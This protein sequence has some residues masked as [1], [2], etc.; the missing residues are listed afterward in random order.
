MNYSD[1]NERHSVATHQA[2]QIIQQMEEKSSFTKY[3]HGTLVGLMRFVCHGGVQ[4][5]ASHMMVHQLA[6]Q[7][8]RSLPINPIHLV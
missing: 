4:I 7:K 5:K 8:P 1:D 2:N 3:D 6:G